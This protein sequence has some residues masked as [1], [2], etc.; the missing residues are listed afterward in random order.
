MWGIPRYTIEGVVEGNRP[1]VAAPVPLVVVQVI[2]VV[3]L[4]FTL[5]YGVDS[6]FQRASALAGPTTGEQIAIAILGGLV[7]IIAMYGV[8]TNRTWTRWLIPI[9]YVLAL[10]VLPY[11]F[12]YQNSLAWAYAILGAAFL[13]V[14]YVMF[15]D[16]SVRQYY[17]E[18]SASD[19]NEMK[20]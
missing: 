10:G 16:S 18:I 12:K 3:W 13:I 2:Y 7:P 19:S 5:L 1:D 20:M 14:L 4:V 17:R 8:A 6:M 11:I 9:S 15:I